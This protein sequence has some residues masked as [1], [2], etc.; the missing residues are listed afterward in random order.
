VSAPVAKQR[1]RFMSSRHGLVTAGRGASSSSFICFISLSI[2]LIGAGISSGTPPRSPAPRRAG[3]TGFLSIRTTDADGEVH[4]YDTRIGPDR[5][6]LTF[7]GGRAGAGVAP[8][9]VLS[10][11]G[12]GVELRMAPMAHISPLLEMLPPELAAMFSSGQLPSVVE[13]ALDEADEP[14]P[15]EAHHPCAREVGACTREMGCESRAAIEQCLVRHF[16]DLSAECKCFVHHVTGGPPAVVHRPVARDA[17]VADADR[18]AVATVSFEEVRVHPVHRLSCLFVFT[19]L[20]LLL[21]LLVRACCSLL[22]GRAP[23]RRIVVVPPQRASIKTIDAP[24]LLVREIKAV[25]VAEPLE[26]H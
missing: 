14:E 11:S 5:M 2:S 26:K 8:S 25:Q 21:F 19:A 18:V 17:G 1:K 15:A 4:Q 20:V 12:R 10:A 9:A 3:A 6:M 16:E 7:G 22:C 23:A 24:P 13:A